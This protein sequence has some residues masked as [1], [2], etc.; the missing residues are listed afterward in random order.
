LIS[1][2]SIK[3]VY[4]RTAF[5]KSDRDSFLK[6]ISIAILFFSALCHA[7]PTPDTGQIAV[8][9]AIE[10]WNGCMRLQ[11]KEK[12]QSIASPSYIAEHVI[13][14]CNEQFIALKELMLSDMM[15]RNQHKDDQKTQQLVIDSLNDARDNHRAK[16]ISMVIKHR[17][18]SS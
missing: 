5:I 10:K 17:K 4:A 11:I 3:T 7:N 6:T 12:I 18:P 9:E 13:S 8:A 2:R 16:L 1:K 15:E 14:Q